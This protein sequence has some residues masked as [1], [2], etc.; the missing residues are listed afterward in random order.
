M[1][2]A[3]EEFAEKIAVRREARGKR[4]GRRE[5]RREGEARGCSRVGEEI[6]RQRE[7][8]AERDCRM[9]RPFARAGQ[10]A[11]AVGGV[12]RNSQIGSDIMSF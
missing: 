11:P 2:E 4:E 9:Y 1:C 3:V 12:N 10:E 8:H 6:A 7:T 5:G